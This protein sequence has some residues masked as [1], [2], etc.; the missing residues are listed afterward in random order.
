MKFCTLTQNDNIQNATEPNFRKKYFSGRKCRKYAGKPVFWLFLEI[1]SFFSRFFAQRCVLTICSKYDRVRFLR[2]NFFRPIMPEIW[3]KS[4]FFHIFIC[5]FT[6][7]R[8]WFI[9]IPM[10]KAELIVNNSWFLHPK[11]SKNPYSTPYPHQQ[12]M[13]RFNTLCVFVDP[14]FSD[15]L[16]LLLSFSI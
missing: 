16:L 4:D 7:R 15:W 6:Q 9:T 13:I 12:L 10:I 3:R 14:L 8:D 11:L 1:L 5:F 2:K